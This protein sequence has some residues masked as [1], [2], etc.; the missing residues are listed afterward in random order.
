MDYRYFSVSFVPNCFCL[1]SPP[2]KGKSIYCNKLIQWVFPREQNLFVKAV[3][4][5]GA[6][7][8][9]PVLPQSPVSVPVLSGA[10]LAVAS[11]GSSSCS[12]A[13][14]FPGRLSAIVAGCGRAV[15]PLQSG[16]CPGVAGLP[17]LLPFVGNPWPQSPA[18]AVPLLHISPFFLNSLVRVCQ[19]LFHRIGCFFAFC[20]L[21]IR[22]VFTSFV[23]FVLSLDFWLENIGY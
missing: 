10:S 12:A 2:P 6:S 3:K 8:V 7:L 14:S 9:W 20:F 18:G 19:I 17:V 23:F 22:S 5:M 21:L 4:E 15:A 1:F 16:A 13:V 11:A